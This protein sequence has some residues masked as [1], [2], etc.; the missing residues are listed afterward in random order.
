VALG[1]VACITG[2]IIFGAHLPALRGPARELI[3]AQQ[4]AGGTPAEEA[5]RTSS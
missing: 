2:G 4:A 3:V 1:G 5:V